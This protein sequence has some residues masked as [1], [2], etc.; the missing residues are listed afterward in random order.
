MKPSKNRIV[1]PQNGRIKMLFESEKK[2]LNFIK[3][4]GDNIQNENGLSPCRA[5]Y[6]NICFGWH[7][8]SKENFKESE[9]N[10]SYIKDNIR[11]SIS[12]AKS[13]PMSNHYYRKQ[14]WK[15]KYKGEY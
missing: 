14:K 8:T 9:L 4:N 13:N 6:C 3:F 1:C 12:K 5:Y 10:D 7:I 15:Q 11:S 2:A